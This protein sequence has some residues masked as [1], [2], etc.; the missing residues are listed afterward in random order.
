MG[1][2]LTGPALVSVIIAFAVLL[3]SSIWAHHR[4]AAHDRL[5]RHFG[6]SLKPTAYGPRWLVIWLPPAILVLALALIA[7]LRAVVPPR[8]VEGDP[9]LGVIIASVATVGAQ[10]FILWLLTRWA[11]EQG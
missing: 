11:R 1:T 4:F 2:V 8:Y 10:G 3:G 9:S 5:P 6:P 7:L